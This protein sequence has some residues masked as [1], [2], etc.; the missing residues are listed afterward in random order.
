MKKGRKKTLQITMH[1]YYTPKT[2]VFQ[3][4][5]SIF[6]IFVN[7]ADFYVNIVMSTEVTAPP[8]LFIIFCDISRCG[9]KFSLFTL[10]VV[11]AGFPAKTLRQVNYIYRK[12]IFVQLNDAPSFLYRFFDPFL[13]L[14]LKLPQFRSRQSPPGQ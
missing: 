2:L 3:A 10:N 9:V 6:T 13:H 1:K 11:F 14:N 8:Q 4:V 5:L 7:Y 12:V